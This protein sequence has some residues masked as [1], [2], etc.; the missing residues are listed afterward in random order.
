MKDIRLNII[1]PEK[2]LVDEDVDN[3]TLPGTLGPFEV[4]KDHAPIISSLERG[5]ISYRTDGEMHEVEISSG[6]AEVRDNLVSVCVEI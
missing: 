6:F 5:K 1:T 2:T 4:L 3:V